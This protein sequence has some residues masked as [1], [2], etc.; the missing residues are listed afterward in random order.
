MNSK[1]NFAKGQLRTLVIALWAELLEAKKPGTP[2]V[3]TW[4]AVLVKSSTEPEVSER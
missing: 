3:L 1:T 2:F 4:N